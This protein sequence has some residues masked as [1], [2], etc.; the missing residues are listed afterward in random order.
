M[1]DNLY[2]ESLE[3]FEDDYYEEQ[4]LKAVN[5]ISKS[6]NL[7]EKI[8]VFRSDS[9]DRGVKNMGVNYI[10]QVSDIVFIANNKEISRLEC[11]KSNQNDY[12][13]I[14]LESFENKQLKFK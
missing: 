14:S 7:L 13:F 10:G 1:I 9:Q 4:I 3:K 12:F 6:E 5:Q 2:L 11:F 8:E